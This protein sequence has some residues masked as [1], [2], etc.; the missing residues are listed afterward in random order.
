MKTFM[1]I[2]KIIAAIVIISLIILGIVMIVKNI[3]SLSAAFEGESQTVI[4]VS[5]SNSKNNVTSPG[6][7]VTQ[8][9]SIIF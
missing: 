7:I 4:D 3:S 2:I 1:N 8:L 6:E 9:E 5:N